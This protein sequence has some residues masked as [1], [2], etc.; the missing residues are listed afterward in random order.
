MLNIKVGSAEWLTAFMVVASKAGYDV[1]LS[2]EWIHDAS[3]VP[4]TLHQ[5][6]IIWNDDGGIEEVGDNDSPVADTC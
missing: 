4:L 2:R 5:K 1:L 3:V 6:L